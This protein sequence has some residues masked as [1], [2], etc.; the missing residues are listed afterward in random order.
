MPAILSLCDRKHQIFMSL[1]IRYLVSIISNE[2]IRELAID[3]LT[4]LRLPQTSSDLIDS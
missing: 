1:T 4:T 2:S 3:P